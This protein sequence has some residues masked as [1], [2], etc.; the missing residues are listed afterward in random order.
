MYK[1]IFLLLAS[2]VSSVHA[3]EMRDILLQ[4]EQYRSP[5]ESARISCDVE[6]FNED[7]LIKEREYV[8]YTQSENRSLVLF[9][10]AADAGQKVLMKGKDFWMFM[11]KSRR[12][13]RITPM[14]KLL[15]EAALGDIATLNWSKL[16][17]IADA[18]STD[19][20]HTLTLNAKGGASSYQKIVLTVDVTDNFPI[21]ADLYLR[22]GMLSKS[23]FFK[24][25]QRQGKKTVTRMTLQD[26]LKPSSKTV[27]HYRDVR[28][29]S[30]QNKLFNP[31]VLIRSNLEDLLAE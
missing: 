29:A 21:Q 22:S 28:P 19:K 7:D 16:Y 25:G 26:K 12:P 2:I 11:P 9:K 15:G 10:S 20:T 1:I 30:I 3:D 13:I 8:V 6:L 14:Q 31:Q 18:V 4:A 5:T 23:A 27:I 24:K 17:D